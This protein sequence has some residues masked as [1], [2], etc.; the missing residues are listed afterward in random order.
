MCKAEEAQK[1]IESYRAAAAAFPIVRG[2]LES[3]NGKV[4]NCKIEK[5]LKAAFDGSG[6]IYIRKQGTGEYEYIEINFSN[7]GNGSRWNNIL[8]IKA[9]EALQDGKRLN[10]SACVEALRNKRA[11]LLHNAFVLEEA[12]R[13]AESIRGE[14]ESIKADLQKKLIAI[15][16]PYSSEARDL[17]GLDFEYRNY[18]PYT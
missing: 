14:L 16:G 2:V 12:A 8:W 6:F 13:N 11:E 7:T 4:F 15:L 17:F 10:A 9:A 3:F 1:R 5:A 18:I